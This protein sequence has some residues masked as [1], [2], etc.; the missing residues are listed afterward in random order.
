MISLKKFGSLL[1]LTDDGKNPFVH[2]PTSREDVL[3]RVRKLGW[4]EFS[5]A[6]IKHPADV[7]DKWVAWR[8][9]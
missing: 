3:N 7:D 1:E 5:I 2:H 4:E 6:F 8:L 9:N